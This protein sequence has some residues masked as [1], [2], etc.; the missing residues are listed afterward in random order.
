MA[1]VFRKDFYAKPLVVVLTKRTDSTK[2]GFDLTGKTVKFRMWLCASGT[3]TDKIIATSTG[4]TIHPAKSFTFDVTNDWLYSVDHGIVNGD[5]IELTTTGSLSGTGFAVSTR[6][7]ARDVSG[8]KFRLGLSPSGSAIEV[9]AA[10]SGTHSFK[11]IGSVKYTWAAGD[12]NTVNTYR[13]EWQV[14]DGTDFE[15]LPANES[16]QGGFEIKVIGDGC[17]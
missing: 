16:G 6:Y 12:L 3:V 7:F 13:A 17:T 1:F 2:Y 4:V 10:G 14:G 9:A 8:H 11:I 5:E 15:V